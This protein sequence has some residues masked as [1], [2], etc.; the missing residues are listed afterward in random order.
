MT[1]L[2]VIPEVSDAQQMRDAVSVP[3]RQFNEHRA[4]PVNP[5]PLA[6]MLMH[7]ETEAVLGGLW[8]DT[9]FMQ[10][11][12]G[13]LFVPEHLRG[14]GHGSQLMTLAEQEAR[15]RRCVGAWL[16][17]FSFQARGFY[18]KLGYAVFGTIDDFPPGHS[19][20]FMKKRLMSSAGPLRPTVEASN[21]TPA[22]F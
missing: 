6:V 1:P 4:G 10:L 2:I 3:L 14:R 22:G 15:R 12:V 17:T 8:G 9:G 19:R 11:H 16:D 5:Q 21:T 13:Q 18:E 20:F 7:P